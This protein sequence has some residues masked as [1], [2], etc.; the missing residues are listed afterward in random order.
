MTERI[1]GIHYDDC[2][3]AYEGHRDKA[4]H[5]KCKVCDAIYA[6]KGGQ[7]DMVVDAGASFEDEECLWCN[8]CDMTIYYLESDMPAD[9]G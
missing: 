3:N 9:N 5:A 7:C 6:H 8:T 1:E 4:T 2:P